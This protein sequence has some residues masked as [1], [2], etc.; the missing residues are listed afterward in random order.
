MYPILKIRVL[1]IHCC[2]TSYPKCCAFE[3]HLLFSIS[4]DQESGWGSFGCLW[5]GGATEGVGSSQS[6]SCRSRLGYVHLKA[7]WGK[8][9][10]WAHSFACWGHR[11]L[12][13]AVLRASFLAD[14]WLGPL[15]VLAVPQGLLHGPVPNM[16][17]DLPH[18]GWD[19]GHSPFVT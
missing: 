17:A 15:H 14:S 11:S 5:L 8:T 12:R 16:A 7:H 4:V 1:I 13:A 18:S 2:I 9:Y 3:R 10:L 6:C 19:R